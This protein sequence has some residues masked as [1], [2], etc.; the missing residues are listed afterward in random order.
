MSSIV[1]DFQKNSVL[2]QTRTKYDDSV[3]NHKNC[4]LVDLKDDLLI[5]KLMKHS[6]TVGSSFY[7]IAN[8]LDTSFK[9]ETQSSYPVISEL[10]EKP[11]TYDPRFNT[12]TR[13]KLLILNDKL[14]GFERQMELQARHKRY[15]E[16]NRL[17]NI[18]ESLNK[19]QN[20]ITLESKRRMETIK[21]LHGIFETQI[22][23]V[24][25]K[26]ENLFMQKLDQLDNVIQSLSDRI[27]SIQKYV[28]EKESKFTTTIESNC[29]VLEKNLSNL[30]KF[31]EEEK[32]ARQ[33]REEQI[34]KKLSEIE[35]KTDLSLTQEIDKINSTYQNLKNELSDL[36][37]FKEE[38]DKKLK[39]KILDEF[40]NI[41]N[42]LVM[43][44]R[45]REESDNDIVE[46]LHKYA[47]I[48]NDY[49][50]FTPFKFQPT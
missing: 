49:S 15:Q 23:S 27:D 18:N 22:T 35:M 45:A 33:E 5:K 46:A 6:R 20:A 16:E 12:G 1:Q 8:S 31:F 21:A 10:L 19:L 44:S 42:G 4:T 29:M 50:N 17:I 11:E 30:Q 24:Q 47:K 2:S 14:V 28:N 37:K 36:K 26:V 43:E 32:M 9:Q 48:L 41:N 34:I 13:S 39:S 40:S 25:N 7:S 3:F 38:S